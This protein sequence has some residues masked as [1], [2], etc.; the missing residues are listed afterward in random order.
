MLFDRNRSPIIDMQ[1]QA[2]DETHAYTIL[3]LI[4]EAARYCVQL[5]NRLKS[6]AQRG[7]GATRVVAG[8]N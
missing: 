4:K 2:R 3:I 7:Q 5:G 8:Q 1:A 6:K